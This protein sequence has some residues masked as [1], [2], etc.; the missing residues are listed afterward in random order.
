MSME[1]S[2][3]SSQAVSIAADFLGGVVQNTATQAVQEL[4]SRR[5]AGSP[6]GAQAYLRLEQDLPNDQRRQEAADA[7]RAEAEADAQFAQMLRAAVAATL[8][9]S[10]GTGPAAGGIT[11]GGLDIGGNVGN[12]NQLAGRDIDNSRRNVRMGISGIVLLALIGGGAGLY[13][14]LQDDSADRD[15][16]QG[17]PANEGASAEGQETQWPRTLPRASSLDDIAAILKPA[18]GPCLSLTRD[19]PEIDQADKAWGVTRKGW[20]HY[21]NANIEFRLFDKAVAEKLLKKN[22]TTS[23]SNGE[24]VGDGFSVNVI[25]AVGG[26]EGEAAVAQEIK[27]AGLMSLN[28]QRDFAP[29]D[30]VQVIKA[31]T[32]GC[33]YTDTD[34]L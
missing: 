31:A 12:R 7:L 9:E 16:Q 23:A 4:I 11:A 14:Q 25:A 22:D 30:G 1:L 32:P 10:V 8:A 3:L 19:D 2:G 29:Y 15:S 17:A 20:C 28:C 6:S 27:A 26:D 24:L 34:V 33:R 18:V 5:L 13:Q 21:K